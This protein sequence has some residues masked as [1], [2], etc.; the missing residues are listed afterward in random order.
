MLDYFL[1]LQVSTVFQVFNS[2][3]RAP[4]EDLGRSLEVDVVMMLQ[5]PLK[6]QASIVGSQQL[7][8]PAEI[9]SP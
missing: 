3:L 9:Y 2:M 8:C 5:G 1:P 4:R 7:L 6:T